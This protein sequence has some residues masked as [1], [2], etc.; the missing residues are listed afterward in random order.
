M[1]IFR[2]RRT[3]V[4]HHIRYYCQHHSTIELLPPSPSW[5]ACFPRQTITTLGVISPKAIHSR[6]G[7][8]DS[9]SRKKPLH[10]QSFDVC[11]SRISSASVQIIDRVKLL[12]R[13]CPP[14]PTFMATGCWTTAGLSAQDTKNVHSFK[15]CSAL[16]GLLSSVNLLLERPVEGIIID[17]VDCLGYGFSTQNT[18]LQQ[19]TF[20]YCVQKRYERVFPAF[21][22]FFKFALNNKS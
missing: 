5:V 10:D 9:E 22:L 11:D 13:F 15:S 19:Y 21:A 20:Q 14:I 4:W 8:R 17:A 1:P 2:K 18:L 16:Y 6:W 3:N 7:F 12:N